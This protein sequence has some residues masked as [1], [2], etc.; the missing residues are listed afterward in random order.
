[1]SPLEKGHHPELDAQKYLD[2]DGAQRIS[3]LL[4]LYN[5]TH[6]WGDQTLM[7]LFLTLDSFRAE[8]REGDLDR[9][10]RLVSHLVEFKYATIRSRSEE[11]AISSAPITPYD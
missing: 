7:Q 11:P 4:G 8:P 6:H 5:G 1:M 9:A 2:Q 10:K 3:L